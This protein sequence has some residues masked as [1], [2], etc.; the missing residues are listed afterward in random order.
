M[1]KANARMSE[2]CSSHQRPE[3]TLSTI[4]PTFAA[5]P[6]RPRERPSISF[7]HAPPLRPIRAAACA[8][9]NPGR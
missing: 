8:R 2:P 6:G 7:A 9:E 1:P 5:T 3:E 4:A